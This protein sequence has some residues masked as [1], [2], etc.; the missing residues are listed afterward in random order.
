[1]AVNLEKRTKITEK[2][3]MS[4]PC[5]I[6]L[7]TE[8]NIIEGL[9]HLNVSVLQSLPENIYPISE[10]SGKTRI[11]AKMAR[12]TYN[13]LHEGYNSPWDQYWEIKGED[14]VDCLY[15]MLCEAT[16][17]KEVERREALDN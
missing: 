13:L 6:K 14:K 5:E 7:F 3:L 4:L 9:K 10:G 12:M 16:Q 8:K 2:L 11:Y 15:M 17:I 1:M